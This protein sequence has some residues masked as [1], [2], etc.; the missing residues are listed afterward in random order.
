[1]IFLEVGTEKNYA[2]HIIFVHIYVEWE[3][4]VQIFFFPRTPQRHNT[5]LCGSNRILFPTAASFCYVF[6]ALDWRAPKNDKHWKACLVID[7]IFHHQQYSDVVRTTFNCFP[8]FHCIVFDCTSSCTL[9]QAF[10]RSISALDSAL[11]SYL[12]EERKGNIFHVTNFDK[13]KKLWMAICFWHDW[14]LWKEKR[15]I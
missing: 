2:D 6:L 4:S 1:M 7:I 8:L 3:N 12:S 5:F 14:L 15:C 10:V 13:Q 11:G 9:S